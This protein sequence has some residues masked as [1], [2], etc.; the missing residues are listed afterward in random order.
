MRTWP[1]A[2]AAL[3]LSVWCQAVWC[4]QEE[5]L[6]RIAAL[7]FEDD[8]GFDAPRGCGCIPMGPLGNLFGRT[9][10]ARERWNLEIGFQEM[11]ASELNAAYGYEAV[12]PDETRAAMAELRLSEKDLQKTEARARLAERLGADALM[13][14]KIET[15]KQE[16]LRG[17]VGG[18]AET[19]GS[20]AAT[21]AVELGGEHHRAAARV[22][23]SAYGP[24]GEEIVSSAPVEETQTYSIGAALTGPLSAAVDSGGPSVRVGSN[25]L[26]P[27]KKRPPIVK[28]AALNRIKF[29]TEGWD[30]PREGG[31]PPSYR[32]T[33]LGIVTQ[34]AVDS[35]V[36]ALREQIG[37]ELPDA[38]QEDGS[39]REPLVGRV[40]A[41]LAGEAYINLGS[42]HGVRRGDRFRVLRE[43]E[44]I[45][46][47][48]TG[49]RLGAAETEV[50]WIRVEE[51]MRPSLSRAEI[52]TGEPQKGDV[53]RLELEQTDEKNGEETN[54]ARVEDAK[55]ADEEADGAE[56]IERIE[57]EEGENKCG[58]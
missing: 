11:L 49:A 56:A 50:G 42:R 39:E 35:A 31:Y 53:A 23:I 26:A 21:S 18:Q 20:F 1:A 7:P 13:T 55:N 57:G 43:G 9:R 27:A 46:D 38:M 37:P 48:E 51:T 54:E 33:L 28:Y 30:A 3:V 5:P 2:L 52:L 17:S 8:S 44:P 16:R 19:G 32:E 4:Q 15:F 45:L 6:K 41:I 58:E 34:K 14:G 22:L 24:R 40:A 25:N 10:G 12:P 47:P 29:G 36:A